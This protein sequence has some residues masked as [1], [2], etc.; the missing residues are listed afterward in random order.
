[1]KSVGGGGK[2]HVVSTSG[3]TEGVAVPWHCQ[4]AGMWAV[5]EDESRR[6]SDPMR[7]TPCDGSDFT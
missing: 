2:D 7:R 5:N 3:C 4:C 1:M 6:A